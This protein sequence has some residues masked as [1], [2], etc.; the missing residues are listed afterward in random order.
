VWLE[1][2]KRQPNFFKNFAEEYISKIDDRRQSKSLI[3][4]EEGSESYDFTKYF[5]GWK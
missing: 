2:N 3:T 4:V 1:D 5:H